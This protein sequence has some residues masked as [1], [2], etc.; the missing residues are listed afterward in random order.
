MRDQKVMR[1]GMR[2][3]EFILSGLV[4]LIFFFKTLPLFV[5][6]NSWKTA[7][8]SQLRDIIS[9]QCTLPSLIVGGRLING[10]GWKKWVP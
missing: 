3:K 1:A 4:N 7:C 5:D 2:N 8:R 6:K 10:S 9:W